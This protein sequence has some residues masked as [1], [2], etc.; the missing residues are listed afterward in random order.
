MQNKNI[1]IK[2]R[3]SQSKEFLESLS[4]EDREE[5]AKIGE[6][7]EKER[8]LDRVNSDLASVAKFAWDS[9]PRLIAKVLF[10]GLK[11]LKLKAFS[12]L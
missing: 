6:F 9:S 3:P 10:R 4:D 2:T 11:Y 5:W 12:P 7:L 1:Q 8:Q